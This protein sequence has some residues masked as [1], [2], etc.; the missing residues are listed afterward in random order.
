MRSAVRRAAPLA[1]QHSRIIF[2]ITRSACTETYDKTISDITITPDNKKPPNTD[3]A[4]FIGVEDGNKDVE[5]KTIKPGVK[6]DLGLLDKNEL[7]LNYFT[8]E[9]FGE[10]KF[11]RALKEYCFYIHK[12]PENTNINSVELRAGHSS[13]LNITNHHRHR[14]ICGA[15]KICCSCL[16]EHEI[17]T[18][19]V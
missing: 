16:T 18:F 12:L 9:I 13:N 19:I 3:I 6:L 14:N 10:W 7:V 11:D 17:F 1:Y 4:Y 5:W 15:L 2:P 8:S